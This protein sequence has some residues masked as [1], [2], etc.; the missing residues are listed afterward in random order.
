VN[1]PGGI[2]KKSLSSEGK[3]KK[4][5]GGGGDGDK[6]GENVLSERLSFVSPEKEGKRNSSKEEGTYPI[7]GF[8]P[9]SCPI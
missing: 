2:R 5:E 1:G 8:S 9:P 4:I 7:G 6:G 3:P